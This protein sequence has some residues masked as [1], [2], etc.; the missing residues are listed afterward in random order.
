M[1]NPYISFV[2]QLAPRILTQIDRDTDSPTF[3]CCD[4]NFWH[5]KVRDFSSAILQQSGLGLALL[6]KNDFPGNIYYA[7]NEIKETAAAALNY[8]RK[9]QHNDGSFDEYW[10]NEHSIPAAVFSLF[11]AVEICKLLEI[12]NAKTNNAILK[13]A[14]FLIRNP[15]KQALNQEIASMCAVYNAALFLSSELL[16]QEAEKK[17]SKLLALQD[18]EG[19]FAEYNGADIGYL[20][21]SLNFM[22]EYYRLS[23]DERAKDCIIR[24]FDFI[25][26]FIHPDGSLGGDYASRNTEYFLPAGFEIAAN[27]CN[28]PEAGMIAERLMVY[29]ASNY[30]VDD[31]YLAHYVFHSFV[32]ALAE[33]NQRKEIKDKKYRKNASVLLP[34]QKEFFKYF[35]N[36]GIAI[37]SNKKHYIICALSKGGVTSVFDKK[38]KRK[39]LN[40][41]GYRAFIGSKVYVTNWI[42]NGYKAEI[43]SP[44]NYT[45]NIL[46]V[47][48]YF[49]RAKFHTPTTVQHFLLR[50]A[51]FF[52]GRK[53]IPLMKKIFILPSKK[54]RIRLTREINISNNGINIKD[55]INSQT[56]IDTLRASEGLSLRYCPSS[57]FFQ[58]STLIRNNYPY[59]EHDIKDAK[60][61]KRIG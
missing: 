33:N 24:I 51:S 15:E 14:K 23:R 5:Y 36:A 58:N 29:A 34:Y 4:R 1:A 7:K 46:K 60:I 26:Y 42:N 44:E 43:S 53:I 30:S 10:P 61:E 32:R 41:C 56:K 12:D 57:R 48:S 50:I 27:L 39:I 6:Y 28:F 11:S 9:I 38:T 19:W 20:T 21:V 22:A 45:N 13:A 37:V 49:Y 59:E 25:K 2:L 47:E 55:E 18:E 3:G 52:V 16:K 17:F 31:R 35:K 54:S 40:D 8:W